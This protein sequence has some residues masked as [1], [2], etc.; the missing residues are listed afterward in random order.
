MFSSRRRREG[1]F[2]LLLLAHQLH[3]VGLEN[4]GP[5]T[6]LTILGQTLLFMGIIN[7]PWNKYDVCISGQAILHHRKYKHL[8]LSA[9]EH[10]DD[11]HLYYNMVSFLIKGRTLEQRFGSVK[12][13]ILLVVFTLSTSLT[14]VGL[15]WL[16]A[17]FFEDYSYMKTC[18]I[19]FSG[20]IFA[21]KV[22]TTHYERRANR[23]VYGI[24]VPSGYAVWVELVII[25]LLVPNASFVGHLAGILVGLAYIHGPL[26]SLI[27]AIWCTV[28]DR[29]YRQ[30]YTYAHGTTRGYTLH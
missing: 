4:V 7:A 2:G 25:H 27:D 10:A 3:N 21:L 15:S 30:S 17:E 18:A 19:G 9:I 1:G 8:F 22:L 14:Y 13:I 5:V 11:M 16:A 29:P 12:F 28:S 26:S 23:Q 24:Y 20:V 6:L